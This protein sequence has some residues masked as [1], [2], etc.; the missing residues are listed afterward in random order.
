MLIPHKHEGDEMDT[1]DARD[2]GDVDLLRRVQRAQ[3]LQAANEQHDLTG[4]DKPEGSA[5]G[6]LVR[7]VARV[8][9]TQRGA[10]SAGHEPE[11][12]DAEQR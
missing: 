12:Q 7:G 11:Q 3:D 9:R 8:H 4:D 5:V 1:H 2:P 6:A 10:S